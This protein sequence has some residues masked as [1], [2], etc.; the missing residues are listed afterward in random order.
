MSVV[1]CSLKWDRAEA[2]A[3]KIAYDSDGYHLVRFPYDANGESY[4]PWKMHDPANGGTA[5]SKYPDARSGL[6][7]PSH[8]GWGVLSAMV[9][10]ESDLQTLEYRARFVR[11]PLNMT[12]KKYDSTG[13][14]DSALTPGG[15]YRTYLWQFFVKKGMPL[16]LKVT[17][18]GLGDTRRTPALTLAEFKLA[19]HTDVEEP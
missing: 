1:V 2:G 7:W 12:A 6:I 11:D 14:T 16:G 19:I 13:T 5:K 18:R 4:D 9:F 17:A 15:Q 10:W 8:D 3:Q